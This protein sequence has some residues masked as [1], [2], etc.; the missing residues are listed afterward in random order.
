MVNY[1]AH[2]RIY[3]V[4]PKNLLTI[5]LSIFGYVSEGGV[6]DCGV[7]GQRRSSKRGAGK[8]GD[9]VALACE[10]HECLSEQ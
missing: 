5:R 9:E 2:K 8:D 4:F 10:L 3:S 1:K 6:L 7:R